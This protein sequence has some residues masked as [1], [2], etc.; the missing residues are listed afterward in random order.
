[1]T[2][3][4]QFDRGFTVSFKTSTGHDAS[5]IVVRG[6][7]AKDLKKKMKSLDGDLIQEIVG[8]EN[9]IHAAYNLTQPED[10]PKKSK[11]SGGDDDGVEVKTC[12]HGK[13]NYRSGKSAKGPWEAWFC[14][15]KSKSDEC[16]PIWG[17][18]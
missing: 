7:D 12:E 1:M 14:P 16:D 3:Q 11:K 13:R 8:L 15:S 17:D 5:L 9:T 6:D 18:K 2:E 10:A 4:Q